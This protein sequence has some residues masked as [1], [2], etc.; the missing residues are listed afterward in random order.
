MYWI[1]VLDTGVSRK[2]EEPEYNKITASEQSKK[3]QRKKEQEKR[4]DRKT[5]SYSLYVPILIIKK[6]H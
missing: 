2:N 4:E 6:E 5:R 3:R 1:Q